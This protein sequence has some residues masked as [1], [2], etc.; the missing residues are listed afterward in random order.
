MPGT[1][2]VAASQFV[3]DASAFQKQLAYPLAATNVLGAYHTPAPAANFNPQTASAADLVKNGF[4]VRRPTKNDPPALQQAWAKVFSHQW[5]EQK[6]IVPVLQPQVG[7]SH[8]LRKMP[9]KQK[10]GNYLNGAWAGA[11][12]D[13]GKWTGVI[14][15]WNIPSV[16]KPTEPQG[17]EGGW[18]SSS[19]IGIDGFGSNDV[20][21]AGIQQRVDGSGNAH[22]VAWYE[23]YAPPQANSPGYVWQ[24]NIANFPVSPGQQVYCS[25]QYVNNSKAGYLY[26]ANE[27]TGQHFAITLAPP[28]GA[29]F[30]GDCVEWIMEAPDGGEPVSALPKFSPV[31]F[32]SAIGCG[33]NGAIANPQTG[34]TVNVETTGGKILTQVSLAS[35]AATVNFIG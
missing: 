1:A 18:N 22:Y 15:F 26:F 24:T 20:L 34:D 32:T 27:A 30:N 13:P 25:A 28:P 8:Q 17:T 31:K 10:D 2:K 29:N 33:P 9:V 6:R 12:V 4:L 16:S 23:W 5:S 7:M 21:Q 11:V 3:H 19:W 14:G 35:F